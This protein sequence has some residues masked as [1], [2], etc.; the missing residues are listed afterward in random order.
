M[1]LRLSTEAGETGSQLIGLRTANI[2]LRKELEAKDEEI[3]Q[4]KHQVYVAS[5]NNRRSGSLSLSK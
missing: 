4:L 3:D 2:T 5:L 1:N